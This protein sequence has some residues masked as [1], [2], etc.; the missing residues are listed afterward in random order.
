MFPTPPGHIPVCQKVH[1]KGLGSPS[2][3]AMVMH[4][5]KLKLQKVKDMR[6]SDSSASMPRNEQSCNDRSTKRRTDQYEKT[7]KGVTMYCALCDE[8]GAPKWVY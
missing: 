7:G 3:F 6:K 5:K 1:Q 4:E 2:F 8:A